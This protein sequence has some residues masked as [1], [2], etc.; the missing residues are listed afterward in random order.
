MAESEG[1]EEDGSEACCVAQEVRSYLQGNQYQ[2]LLQDG[3]LEC[4]FKWEW[5]SSWILKNYKG[6]RKDVDRARI[7]CMG[8]SGKLRQ[9]TKVK[10]A[11]QIYVLCIYFLFE[12]DTLICFSSEGKVMVLET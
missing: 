5:E 6:K 8:H 9:G 7:I 2:K 10:E 12:I 11:Q 3:K 1:V 4:V